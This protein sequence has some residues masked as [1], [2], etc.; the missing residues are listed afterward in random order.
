MSRT[1]VKGRYSLTR[2]IIACCTFGLS[3]PILGVR[4]TKSVIHTH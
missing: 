4:T 3:I 1:V 2:V